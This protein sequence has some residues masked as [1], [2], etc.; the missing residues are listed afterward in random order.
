MSRLASGGVRP[1]DET[2]YIQATN[3]N[4]L[5]VQFIPTRDEVAKFFT[6]PLSA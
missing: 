1:E 2:V 3:Q 6:T 5:K 4:I